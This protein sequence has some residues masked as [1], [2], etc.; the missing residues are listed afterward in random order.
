ML[1]DFEV[2]IIK[3]IVVIKLNM[4]RAT[5]KEVPEFKKIIQSA[6][7][8]GR[9][10]VIIDLSDCD[11]VDSSILGVIVIMTKVLRAKD[12]DIRGVIKEGSV[13]NMFTQT[14]LEKVFKHFTT[15]NLA[16]SSFD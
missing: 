15:L 10:K 16:V 11:F 12:G 2:D 4:L 9:N 6:I 8:K 3:G 13:L 5:V 14:G 7:D 1:E